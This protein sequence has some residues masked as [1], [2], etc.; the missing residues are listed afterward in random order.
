VRAKRHRDT[1][2]SPYSLRQRGRERIAARGCSSLASWKNLVLRRGVRWF[3]LRLF[4]SITIIPNGQKRRNSN[5]IVEARPHDC[6]H[7]LTRHPLFRQG[8]SKRDSFD[9][10]LV[11]IKRVDKSVRDRDKESSYTLLHY[12][13]YVPKRKNSSTRSS[14]STR[15]AGTVSF[16]AGNGRSTAFQWTNMRRMVSC[17][18]SAFSNT[19]SVWKTKSCIHNWPRRA[20]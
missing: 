6:D 15:K 2:V 10:D 14:Y 1:R 7:K 19:E 8:Q 11:V 9:D 3:S 5:Y 12:L 4:F 17:T 18:T 16:D 13:H 20:I